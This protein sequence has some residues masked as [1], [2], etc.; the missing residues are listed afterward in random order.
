M[1][2][3]ARLD[4][5]LDRERSHKEVGG[6]KATVIGNFLVVI[7]IA[8]F[9]QLQ[10]PT[11]VFVLSLAIADFFVGIIVMPYS[12]IRTIEGCWF[13]GSLFCR[14]HSSLDV[15]LCTASIFHLSCIAFD[16]YYA[17]CNPLVYTYKMSPRRVT[18]LVFICW[19]IPLLISFVPIM[20]GL[21]MLGIENVLPSDVC[22]LLAN[23][24]YAVCASFVA[25]YLPMLIMLGAY[26]KIYKVAKRQAMQ[27]DAMENQVSTQNSSNEESKKQKH[28][29]KRERKAAKTLGIIIGVFLIFWLPFF[30]TNI[31]DPFIGF[32][33]DPVFWEVFLWL[34]YINSSMNPFLYAFFHRSFRRA[35][36]IIIGWAMFKVAEFYPAYLRTAVGLPGFHV[37]MPLT[38]VASRAA[39]QE[40]Y[41]L[42][43]SVSEEPSQCHL[44]C[45]STVC[46]QL[47]ELCASQ[48][49]SLGNRGEEKADW[50]YYL[51]W[52]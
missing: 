29:M 52:D 21:H 37:M 23:Q 5:E 3:D 15:M 8:Y 39:T 34:G 13:F 40:V 51:Q 33:M 22:F 43:M 14:I 27:I 6:P 36:F 48:I 17:V 9:K 16:R 26:W 1:R 50:F 46:L 35:F 24:V 44:C 11:N 49:L 10:S 41:I 19:V 31:I 4:R 12:M 20:L 30:T 45:H 42:V 25:F 28:S 32:Q 18:T 47:M 38:V 2:G 7:S